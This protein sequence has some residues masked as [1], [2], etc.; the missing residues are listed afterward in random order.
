VPINDLTRG[1]QTFFQSMRMFFAIFWKLC[2]VFFLVWIISSVILLYGRFSEEDLSKLWILV[3][4]EP[5]AFVSEKIDSKLDAIGISSDLNSDNLSVN[6]KHQETSTENM[7]LKKVATPYFEHYVEKTLFWCILEALLLALFVTII[8]GKLLMRYGKSIAEKK[9]I[10]GTVIS[11]NNELKKQISRQNKGQNSDISIGNINL[12]YR[13]ETQHI[14]I[15]GTTGSGKTVAFSDILSQ[16]RSKGRRAVVYDLMGVYVERFYRPGKDIILNPLDKRSPSW[17]PWAE[18]SHSVDYEMLAASQIPIAPGVN[19]EDPFWKKASRSLYSA[20]LRRLAKIGKANNITL[21][22]YLLTSDL[23]KLRELLQNTEAESLVSKDLEKTALSVKAILNDYIRGMRFLKDSEPLFSIRDWVRNDDEDSWIFI[24]SRPDLHET[25]M[26]LISTWYDTAITEAL[27]LPDKI[28]RRIYFPLDEMPTLQYLPALRKGM[29]LGRQKG[30]CFILGT[31]DLSQIRA[32]YGP[33]I[34]NSLV[35]NA[36]TKLILRSVNDADSISNLFNKSE[37]QEN[38]ES[39]SYGVT[40]NRDGVSI[41]K[42]HNMQSVVLPSELQNLDN[43]AGYLQVPGNYPITKVILD[44]KAY[45]KSNERFIPRGDDV[46]VLVDDEGQFD[47]NEEISRF[48]DKTIEKKDIKYS[49]NNKGDEDNKET[50]KQK[51]EPLQAE[52]EE[53]NVSENEK[54]EMENYRL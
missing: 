5:A 32:C 4:D 3:K 25:L 23:D 21:L 11:S 42:Q 31:Q 45:D 46:D 16:V 53:F 51:N 38:T 48:E 8:I 30:L 33:D 34:T 7:Q 19:S 22:R 26:P 52:L 24:T 12:P 15:N 47:R 1:G 35:G 50:N 49:Q 14:W 43:L 2:G 27:S 44:Y 37:Y 18:C 9:V 13:A 6:P 41:S 39:I 28:D 36:N 20:T 17:S 29:P 54:L 40:D 10:R